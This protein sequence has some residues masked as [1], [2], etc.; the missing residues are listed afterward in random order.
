MVTYRNE[1]HLHVFGRQNDHQGQPFFSEIRF[2]LPT[3]VGQH[4]PGRAEAVP[5]I[6]QLV[7]VRLCERRVAVYRLVK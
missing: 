1:V 7:V 6:R 2:Q 5:G 3:D 4:H